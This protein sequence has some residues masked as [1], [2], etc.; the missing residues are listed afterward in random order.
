MPDQCP[1]THVCQNGTKD[2]R[3]EMNRVSIHT[4][5]YHFLAIVRNGFANQER[6]DLFRWA[7]DAML[8]PDDQRR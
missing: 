6:A 4:I 2:P 8:P 5:K 1:K 7:R 3:C